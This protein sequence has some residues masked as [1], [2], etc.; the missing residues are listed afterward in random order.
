MMSH[1]KVHPSIAYHILLAKF[2]ELPKKLNA[3]TLSFQQ[4]LA[5]L[6]S[7]W[8]V[9]QEVSLSRHLAEQGANT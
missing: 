5:H 4:R 6:P 9:G 7:S 2:G 8:L 1:I 3:L